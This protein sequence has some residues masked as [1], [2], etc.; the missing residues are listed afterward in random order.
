[1]RFV[2][3]F[4]LLAGLL[5]Q[6]HEPNI[7]NRDYFPLD[8]NT[9]WEY[10]YQYFAT[11]DNATFL[12]ADTVKLTIKGDTLLD[13]ITYKKVVDDLGT[14]KK[15]LRKEGNKYYGRNH[16]LYLG[17][18][19]EY[20]F[21]DEDASLNS[22]WTHD[23][24]DGARTVYTVDAVNSSRTYNGITYTDVMELKVEYY[25]GDDFHYTTRHYYARGV[26]EIYA[27]YPYPSSFTYSDL[28]ISLLKYVPQ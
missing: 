6:C 7:A 27:F 17:F 12:W 1:M 20:L 21:L 11:D 13:G 26:G 18:T 14:I 19:N 10:T 4:I 5:A 3:I 2:A 22:T 15:A 24:G 25:S 28:D 9:G 16:E 23:K 8:E